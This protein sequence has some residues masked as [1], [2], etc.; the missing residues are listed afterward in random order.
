MG[1]GTTPLVRSKHIGPALGM[2]HLY[3]KLESLNPTGSYKD[4]FAALAISGLLHRQASFCLATSSGNTGA[5]LAA[6]AALAGMPCHIVVVD[7]APPGKL[8]QMQAYGAKLWMVKEFGIDEKVTT[9]VFTG[10]QNLAASY[11]MPVQI[12]AFRYSPFGMQGVQT[13]AYEIAEELSQIQHVFVPAG[14][15]GLTLA[16]ARGF[17]VWNRG[18]NTFIHPKVHCV[19]P[20]GNNTIAGALRTG[21]HRARSIKSSTTRIS[22]LQVPSVIDGDEVIAACR[23]HGGNGFLV[24]DAEVQSLQKQLAREEGIFCEPAAAVALAGCINAVQNNECKSD[25]AVV[26]L[27]T[28]HG[29]KDQKAG[30]KLV[31]DNPLRHIADLKELNKSFHEAY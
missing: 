30:E 1:E 11:A 10:L 22:G 26:C 7:G 20:E 13:I 28:G 25:E 29:F 23:K 16:V 18:N 12:S 2:D 3:F 4:R 27:I 19:Q 31:E 24:S 5:S 21:E 9:E 8:A 14:G 17:A 15:G 6:Y